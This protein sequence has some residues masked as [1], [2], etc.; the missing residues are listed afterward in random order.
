MAY[1]RRIITEPD[2]ILRKVA[3]KVTALELRMPL[4]QQLI[5][6]MIETMHAAPG[7]GLAAPQVGISKRIFVTDVADD[8]EDERHKLYVFI[9]PVLTD[10]DGEET[11]AEGCLSIP[12]KIGDVTRAASCTITALDRHGKKIQVKAAG[13]LARCI[14]HE[15]DHLDGILIIDK[16]TNIREP[17][18]VAAGNPKETE[19]AKEVNI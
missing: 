9:N 6:D 5:D 18:A 2:P 15:V 1:K 13:L 10:F 11:A 19:A 3:K 16:A 12:G 17:V 7:I 14:Q 4:T 8:E